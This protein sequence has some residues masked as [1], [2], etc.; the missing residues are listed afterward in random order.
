MLILGFHIFSPTACNMSISNEF[1]IYYLPTYFVS[2]VA[3]LSNAMLLIALVKDPLKCFRNSATYLIGNLALSDLMYM[4]VVIPRSAYEAFIVLQFLSFNSSFGTIF[5]IALDRYFMVCHPF[6]HRFFMSGNRMTLWIGMVW[7]LSSVHPLKRIFVQSDDDFLVQ[8]GISLS[9]ILLSAILY[10]K[11]YYTL[12]MQAKSMLEKRSICLPAQSDFASKKSN[13]IDAVNRI[14]MAGHVEN[15]SSSQTPNSFAE[16]GHV[17]HLNK[18][19]ENDDY[20]ARDPH[21]RSQDGYERA[22]SASGFNAKKNDHSK[23]QNKRA[24]SLSERVHNCDERAESRDE[25]AESR[26]E[27][28]Q[29][30]DERVHCLHERVQN[31]HIPTRSKRVESHQERGQNYNECAQA[32]DKHFQTQ[33]ERVQKQI[34]RARFE[35]DHCDIPT[36]ALTSIDQNPSPPSVAT[37]RRHYS[38]TINNAREQKFLNTIIIISFVGV[39]TVVPGSVL[40]QF[41]QE[42]AR[43]SSHVPGITKVLFETIFSVNFAANPFIY[44]WRLERYKKTFKILFGCKT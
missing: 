20:R 28:A 34:S 17:V 35:N 19:A 4:C 3:I 23:D 29:G 11:A 14:N 36:R 41:W 30:H 10:G 13:S 27:R 40:Y 24:K 6:K 1:Q 31:E 22:H 5:S 18:R 8:P 43:D 12:K 33:S 42:A 25:R 32:Q 9:F 21:E 26:D 2:F 7:V 38:Q 37:K 44:C 16:A 39:I 15:W